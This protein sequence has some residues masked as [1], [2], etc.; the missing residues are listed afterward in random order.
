LFLRRLSI[1]ISVYQVSL[2]WSHFSQL[3]QIGRFVGLVIKV[4]FVHEY[5]HYLGMLHKHVKI[6]V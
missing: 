5:L 4:Y 6:N 3:T 2:V 1:F